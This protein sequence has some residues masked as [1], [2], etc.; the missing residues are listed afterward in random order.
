MSE[1]KVGSD[2][3]IVD[4]SDDDWK[5]LN[6]LK[7][8]CEISSR[9]DIATGYFEIGSLLALKDEW[10]KVDK[11][12]ILMGDEV[13]LRTKKAFEQGLNSV[14]GRLDDSLELE[15]E[16]NDFLTGVPAIVDAIDSGKIECRVYRKD[17][18]HAKAYITYARQEVI[19]SSALVG[20]SNMTFPGLVQNIELNVQ[21]TGRPVN[22]LQE[23]YEDHWDDAEDVSVEI[24][25]VIERHT[26]EYSPFEVYAKSLQEFFRGHEM[27]ADEWEQQESQIYNPIL[28]QYQRDGYRSLIKM[29]KR[30][31]GAFLCDGVGL[32]KTFIG[33]MLIE[34]LVVHENRR[35][36]L[37]VPKAARE[38]VWEATLKQ[39]LPDIFEGFYT[40]KIFNHTDLQREKLH[41]ELEQ[42]RKQA[43]VII[44]DEAHHFRNLGTRG[45]DES[46]R[47]S[48]YWHMF[49][50]CDDKQVYMLTATPVNNHLIDLQHM[51]ELF[52]R[53]ETNYFKDA[54]LGIHSLGGHFRVMENTL[55]KAMS[56]K[57]ADDEVT[58]TNMSEAGDILDQDELFKALVVQRSRTYVKESDK[59][60]GG[61]IL[62]PKPREPKVAEY[63]VKQTYG[64]ILTMVEK[65][66][67]KKTPL[68]SLAAYYPY[69]YYIGEGEADPL[70]KGRQKQVVTLIRTNFLKRFESSV[71]AFRMSCWNLMKK[72]LTWV[73]AHAELDREKEILE[74]IKLKHG[75][76]IGYIHS[77]QK[78]LFGEDPEDEVDE[79]I[80]TPEMLALV[81]KLNREEFDVGAIIDQTI[82][83]INE[84]ADFLKELEKFKPSHDKKLTKLI[85]LLKNDNVLK[86]HKVIIFTEFKD[87][88]RY[89][90]KQLVEEGID[91]VAEIDSAVTGDRGK[92][93]RRFSPYYNGS[94]SAELKEQGLEEIR[95]L[96]STDVL[97]EGLNLQDATRLINYDLHWNPVRLMQR[98][99]RIDRRMNPDIEDRIIKDHPDQE[100][101]RG[102]TAYW[103]FLP[104]DELNE[105]LSLYKKVTHKTL[106]I[107]K[108]FGIEGKKLLKPDDDYDDLKDFYESYEGKLSVIEQMHLEYQ[109]LLNDDASLE[110]RLNMLP[111][112]VFSGKENIK[113][114][115]QAVF[116]CFSRPAYDK[117]ASVESGE[118][119]W[120]LEAGDVKWYL[121]D[122]N[123]EGILEGIAEIHEHIKCFPD[124]ERKTNI[125]QKTL[126]EIR[127]KLEKYIKNT[128]LKQVQAP[129]GVKTT[130]NTWMELN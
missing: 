62:F 35:V 9:I 76:L 40:F 27:T 99:G 47:K 43:N 85:Q 128:Y 91:G 119:E 2:L 37:F 112:R 15:K 68:F 31:N 73:E 13:S 125:E 12:R 65:S 34:R 57:Y 67:S 49:D 3:F 97:S 89:L 16:K 116:F 88:A 56:E 14:K 41:N 58:D 42:V 70:A 74:R 33:L 19:G 110:D 60:E 59:Q 55:V 126:I 117:A 101:L 90:K 79:D 102:E 6:Y 80:I 106:R 124:T 54:P 23:W 10:Q 115:T 129:V 61:E 22:A 38:P 39:Y 104:P 44:I 118:D 121:Y 50:L 113:P 122:C 46:Q 100:K 78:E 92:L 52:S 95:V 72:L 64:K 11:I 127:K 69:G 108:T 25:Q 26:R 36:A 18:F 83:D 32:G 1:K 29:A 93:I 87:T 7:G 53:R 86:E 105:L 123:S 107:S 63:S 81:D 103:N 96:V 98:I 109:K 114:D 28:A 77:H 120:T 51:I 45:E 5:V 111:R 8:W 21:I 48:R 82:E 84:I 4:N 24:L 130:L 75:D 20:S 94:S 30:Y 71:E 66:F 17:K